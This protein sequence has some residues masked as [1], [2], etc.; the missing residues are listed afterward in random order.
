MPA[1]AASSARL[2]FANRY[3]W[4][5]EPATA[6]LLTDLAE[7]LAARGWGVTV[8]AS[9]SRAAPLPARETR[10]GVD[11][12]RVAATRWGARSILGKAFDYFTF[13]SALRRAL[14]DELPGAACLVAMTDPPTLAPLAAAA[15][16]RTGSRLVHW[17]QDIHPEISLAL[18]GGRL[19][20]FLA[21]P[22]V[23]RRD[24][25]WRRAEA[26]VTVSSDMAALVAA[27]GVGSERIRVVPNWAPGG[28]LTPVPSEQNGLRRQWGLA[29]RFVVAYSG[30]LGRVHALEP[31]LGAAARLRDEGD[32]VFLLVGDGPQRPALEQLAKK[33]H[34]SNVR[35]LPPQPRARL[36][37]SLSAADLH[38]V[39]L[40]PGCEGFVFPS[41][42]YGIAAVGRAAI[43][44]GPPACSLARTIEAHGWGVAV[45]PGDPA[46]L[47]ATV[48]ALR[49]DGPRRAGMQEAALR[50]S[51]AG[52]GLAAAL[53]A[54]D[55]LLAGAPAAGNSLLPR[56]RRP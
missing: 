14:R 47:A 36:A 19:P 15:T 39:T 16:R 56:G 30:N 33:Q 40:R 45:P 5:D 53:V 17:V 31:V 46:A 44:V 54:W 11:I 9:R 8:I 42:I 41:K 13:S 49:A 52:G 51:R 26:C 55:G 1:P 35:F 20:P 25:A 12:I 38:L 43:F 23:R 10:A 48:R 27:H 2:V 29:D 3:Y 34:L 7:G 22:W 6:Q 24:A 37:E 28:A 18:A 32:V 21:R 50:W 4:P